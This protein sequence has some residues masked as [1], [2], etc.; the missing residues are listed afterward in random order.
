LAYHIAV[1][2]SSVNSEV[3]V[4]CAVVHGLYQPWISIL[5][6]G[7]APTWLSDGFPKNFSV[8]HF[9][10]RPVGSLGRGIDRVHEKIRWGGRVPNQILRIIDRI[11]M[12]PFLISIPK[13][14]ISNSLPARIPGIRIE[15]PDIYATLRWKDLAIIEYFCK[16]TDFDFLF[17]TTSSSYIRPFKLI[18]Y[19]SKFEVGDVYAGSKPYPDAE[20]VSGA[21]RILSRST[22]EAVLS[23][24]VF[25]DP[26]V[27]EDVALGDLIRKNGIEY[28]SYDQCDIPSLEYLESLS[29]EM[30]L[31][32]YHFRVKSGSINERQDVQIMKR[33]SERFKQ[34]ESK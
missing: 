17:M 23:S 10:G 34:I 5:E 3:K 12:F 24:R 31:S 30:L 20:F 8:V 14:T 6:N 26:A 33:L 19:C 27:I 2:S 29:D 1:D 21:N 28:Q 13:V 9:H 15:W 16:K 11:L 25:W 7:Q 22:A 4:L 32:N 18:E